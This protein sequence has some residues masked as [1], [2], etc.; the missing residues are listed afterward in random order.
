MV[1]AFCSLAELGSLPLGLIATLVAKGSKSMLLYCPETGRSNVKEV[2]ETAPKQSKFHVQSA[3]AGTCC[4][5]RLPLDVS[6]NVSILFSIVDQILL[7]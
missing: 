2:Y 3:T 7:F 1:F 4:H 5:W 6:R